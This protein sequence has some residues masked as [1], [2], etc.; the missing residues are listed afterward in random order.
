MNKDFECYITKDGKFKKELYYKN[1][2]QGANK[3]FTELFGGYTYSQVENIIHSYTIKHSNRSI[4]NKSSFGYTY[5][6]SINICLFCN[7][8]IELSSRHCPTN[9]CFGNTSIKSLCHNLIINH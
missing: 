1:I 4:F 2:I 7:L 8:N 6:K 3:I 5:T 9:C